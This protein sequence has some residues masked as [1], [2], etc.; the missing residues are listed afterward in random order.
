MYMFPLISC[1]HALMSLG[2]SLLL[3]SVDC[4]L[5]VKE[6][7]GEFPSVGVSSN[8]EEPEAPESS[9]GLG[10][11]SLARAVQRAQ[12]GV[13]GAPGTRGFSHPVSTSSSL[14]IFIGTLVG[15]NG[16]KRANLY[17]S[18]CPRTVKI[19]RCGATSSFLTGEGLLQLLLANF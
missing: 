9:M 12:C 6:V 16:G 10:S 5:G 13:L 18:F 2:Y 1:H 15:D 11:M 7:Q 8:H 3:L 4:F 17:L 14:N 19:V